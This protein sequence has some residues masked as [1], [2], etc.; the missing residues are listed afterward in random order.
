MHGRIDHTVP[1]EGGYSPPLERWVAPASQY[2]SRLRHDN[3]TAVV[4]TRV[5]NC[6]HMWPQRDNAC[7]LDGTALAWNWVSR[8]SR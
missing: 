2:G 8:F 7:K 1:F 5:L 6:G 4:T 3:P